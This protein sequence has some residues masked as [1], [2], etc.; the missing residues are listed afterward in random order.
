MPRDISGLRVA[1]SFV[2]PANNGTVER[3]LDF[4]LATQQ[5]IAIH[6]VLGIV[7]HIAITAQTAL[8]AVY[9]AQTLHL[10]TGTLE[11]P[12][13]DAA[14]DA[15][16]I[17]TEIFYEQAIGI[18]HQEEAATRGGSNF[19]GYITPS[20]LVTFPIPI[21]SARNITH[22]G[23]I[24]DANGEALFGVFIYYNYVHF[25]MNEI[26]FLLARRA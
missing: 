9:A 5:G 13:M 16:D 21:L 20:G 17:D 26:G 7:Q 15:D 10:E 1:R 12:P 6:G 25:T 23:E 8:E 19:G 18:S 24:V 11:A 3:E 14:E 22:R 2:T 4:Q